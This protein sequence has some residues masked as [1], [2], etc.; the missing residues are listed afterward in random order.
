MN[1]NLLFSDDVK[2]K[3]SIGTL[4]WDLTIKQNPKQANKN[5]DAQNLFI[6][7]KLKQMSITDNNINP[8]NEENNLPNE[9]L[10]ANQ[11]TKVKCDIDFYFA[12]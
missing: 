5:L 4:N 8:V 12:I 9:N 7:D 2:T 10:I 6:D 1:L 11:E 3:S